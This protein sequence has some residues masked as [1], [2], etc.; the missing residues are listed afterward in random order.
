MARQVT[1]E[2]DDR[3]EAAINKMRVEAG[4]YEMPRELWG[5]P[6]PAGSV[7][8]LVIGQ[9]PEPTADITARVP[10]RLVHAAKEDT[11]VTPEG[12]E[13]MMGGWSGELLRHIVR[14]IRE[15]A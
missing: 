7:L 8:A 3:L 14:Q 4:Q 5:N 1:I 15:E 12:L 6:D 10:A 2:L 9:L 11:E 13:G